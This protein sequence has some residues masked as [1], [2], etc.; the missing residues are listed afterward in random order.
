MTQ[1]RRSQ[2][3]GTQRLPRHFL[4]TPRDPE[5]I[6]GSRQFRAP[7]E[8]R[9]LHFLSSQL[10]E[11]DPS[12]TGAMP[13]LD[14]QTRSGREEQGQRSAQLWRLCQLLDVRRGAD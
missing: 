13:G 5:H 4:S 14:R 6:Q 7:N 9:C 12:D 8:C 11:G 10:P 3:G 1:G 2:R